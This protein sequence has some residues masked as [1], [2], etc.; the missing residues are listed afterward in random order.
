MLPRDLQGNRVRQDIAEWIRNPAAP[1][2]SGEAVRPG[3]ERLDAFCRG[4]R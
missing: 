1:L 4:Y 2:S 3:S